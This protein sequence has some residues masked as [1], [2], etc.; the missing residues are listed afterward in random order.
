MIRGSWLKPDQLRQKAARFQSSQNGSQ[1]IGR[2]RVM[3]SHL[4]S[5]V[6]G[7]IDEAGVRHA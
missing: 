6:I 3:E 7:M 5:E 1:P 2:F 4:V